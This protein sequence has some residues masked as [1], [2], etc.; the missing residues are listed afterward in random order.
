MDSFSL[1]SENWLVYDY[2]APSAETGVTF[3]F[4]NALSGTADM[5]RETIAQPLADPG[6]GWL[7]CN[8][9]GQEGTGLA[10]AVTVDLQLIVDDAVALLSHVQ[11][12]RPVYVGL[13]IGG[14]FAARV[15]LDG[16]PCAGLVFLN[17]LRKDGPRLDWINAAV[18]RAAEV[19]GSTLLMDMYA[20]LL[21]NQEWQAENR[22]GALANTAYEP[23]DTTSGA[24]KLLASGSTASWDIPWEN[25]DVPALIVTGNRDHVFYVE[26]DV[27][28]IAAR[29]PLAE[30]LDVENAG[31]MVPVE[32][33]STLVDALARFAG[34]CTP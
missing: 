11:P 23:I 6:H 13:S 7:L 33:P 25:L 20:P 15:H 22:A 10:P 32:R 34:R 14:L 21:F 29:L 9:R 4:F 18:A 16:P 26:S 27:A 5:W 3:V 12:I 30:R 19:G 2:R 8:L 24:Y 17:T 31:H 1:D 28:E